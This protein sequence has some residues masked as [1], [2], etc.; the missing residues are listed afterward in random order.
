MRARPLQAP[1]LPWPRE[2]VHESSSWNSDTLSRVTFVTP[3]RQDP[4][5]TG[6]CRFVNP[7]IRSSAVS[8]SSRRLEVRATQRAPASYAR[9][10]SVL[11]EPQRRQLHGIYS[12]GRPDA[13]IPLDTLHTVE[14]D[15]AF[16]FGPF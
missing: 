1:Q 14:S 7:S 9:S 2:R 10:R 16:L 13:E 5:E 3:S 11:L 8:G 12:G 15:L 6:T 4:P